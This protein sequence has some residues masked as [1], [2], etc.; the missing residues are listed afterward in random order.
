LV[1]LKI[2]LLRKSSHKFKNLEIKS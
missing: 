2:D 1:V